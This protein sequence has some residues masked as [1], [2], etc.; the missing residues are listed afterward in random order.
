VELAQVGF[1]KAVGPL[2]HAS[3]SPSPYPSMHDFPPIRMSIQV[4]LQPLFLSSFPFSSFHDWRINEQGS[5]QGT[6]AATD[7][8]EDIA[9]ACIFAQHLV[10]KGRGI[11]REGWR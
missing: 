3:S 2:S 4:C 10:D 7:A 6:G 11:G 8:E 9:L 1:P 5:I